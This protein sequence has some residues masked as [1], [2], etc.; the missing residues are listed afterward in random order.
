TED[1]LV[2][3]WDVDGSAFFATPREVVRRR[4]RKEEPM[5][6]C[7]TKTNIRITRRHRI[8]HRPRGGKWTKSPAT[9]LVGGRTLLP[10]SGQARPFDM[11]VPASKKVSSSHSRRVARNA[12]H[13]RVREGFGRDESLKEARRRIDARESLSYTE[14]KNL[15]FDDCRF[16]G[17]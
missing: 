15:S 8:I 14:P 1:H 13:L 3:N 10:V 12:Y 11:D 7:D 4:R 16:I 2:A 5:V 9:D 6:T 17:F